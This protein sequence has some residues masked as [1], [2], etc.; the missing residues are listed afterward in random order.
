M[1]K[2]F[3]DPV[4]STSTLLSAPF[5]FPLSHKLLNGRAEIQ[6]QGCLSPK[7]LLLISVPSQEVSG[8]DDLILMGGPFRCPSHPLSC[9]TASPSIANAVVLRS[10]PYALGS[11]WIKHLQS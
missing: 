5:S 2:A 1:P 7:L 11:K 4:L 3:P 10:H 9:G 6:V 8:S